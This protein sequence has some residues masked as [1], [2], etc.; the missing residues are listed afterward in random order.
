M[1]TFPMSLDISSNKF[2]HVA[3]EREK[4]MQMKASNDS[5]SI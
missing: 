3:L 4:E 1:L 2:R 5:I